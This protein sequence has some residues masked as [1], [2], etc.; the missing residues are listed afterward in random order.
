[1][2]Q[3]DNY[4]NVQ[5]ISGEYARPSAGGY[6]CKITKVTDVDINPETGKGEYLQIE[7]DF[8]SEELKDYHKERFEKFGFWGGR[9]VRSYKEAALGMFKHFINCIEE[10]CPNFTW[11]WDEKSL[12]GKLIGLVLGEEEYQ[13]NDGSV[14]TRLYVKE[15]KNIQ[16]IRDGDFKVPQIKKL[17][18]ENTDVID[19]FMPT[20]IS[21]DELPF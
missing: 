5:A 6:I 21:D 2:K 9:F 4:E 17:K 12:E 14:G 18:Q 7:Y 11:E 10:S 1:M 8:T 19:D 3:I 16:Q 13:K 20:D 15:I